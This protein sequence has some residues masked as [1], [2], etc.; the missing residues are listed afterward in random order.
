MHS[1]ENVNGKNGFFDLRNPK[2][3]L[4]RCLARSKIVGLTQKFTNT[5]AAKTAK[6]NVAC[7][8]TLSK[9]H[10]VG[11]TDLCVPQHQ[12]DKQ[13]TRQHGVDARSKCRPPKHKYVIR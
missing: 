8:K 11:A 10:A 3:I 7:R 13:A 2:K 5:R 1:Q 4:G 6:L 9:V 12:K